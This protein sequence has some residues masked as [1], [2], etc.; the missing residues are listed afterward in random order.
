MSKRHRS[1]SRVGQ[2]LAATA[3]EGGGKTEFGLSMAKPVAFLSVDPNTKAIIEKAI[4]EGRVRE[5][6]VI[7]HYVRMPA[8]AFSDKDDVQGEA[9]ESWDEMIDLL[10]PYVKG[11]GDPQPASCVLDT[12]TEID[13]LNILAE[14]GKTDQI[15]PEQRR[16]RMGPVNRRYKGIVEALMRAGV[17]VLL[18]HRAGDLY[19]TVNENVRVRGGGD[20]EAKREKVEGIWA[21]ERR[22]FKE[23]GFIT[24]T[25]IFLAHDET[26]S[27]KLAGQFG[28]KIVRC[29]LRPGLKGKE[30]W[31]RQK[32]D[33]GERIR[34]ASFPFLMTQVYPHTSLDDWS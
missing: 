21:L 11:D 25:E 30:F 15:S 29:S 33:D 32:L 9:S 34:R 7:Q 23:T 16:N 8:V 19:Q 17:N 2:A 6:D 14:F 12:A 13:T 4:S 31:G 22:G 18:L 24:S 5:E 3:R 1:S 27:E 28:M 10:R 26:K 20:V